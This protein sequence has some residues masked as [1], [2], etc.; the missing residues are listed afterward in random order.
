MRPTM[1]RGAHEP[2][3]CWSTSY[4]STEVVRSV[5]VGGG[6]VGGGTG[7][8][9][10]MVIATVRAAVA[11]PTL[12]VATLLLVD[13]TPLVLNARTEKYQVPGESELTVAERR[14]TSLI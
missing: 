9:E 6:L 7:V 5:P 4:T 12:F 10:V 8:G 11:P 13:S 14:V 2:F 3:D 1:A